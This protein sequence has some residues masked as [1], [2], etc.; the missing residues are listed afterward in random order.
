MAG[1]DERGGTGLAL[2]AG[3][4]LALAVAMGIGRFLYTP[5]LPMMLA[6]TT[7][8]PAGGGYVA[9]ANFAGYLAGALLAGAGRPARQPRVWLLAALAISAATTAGMAATE[10]PGIWAA[11]RFAGGAAS[12]CVLVTASAIVLRRLAATGQSRLGAVHFAGVGTGIA[13]SAVLAAPAVTGDRDWQ[14]LWL[15]GGA[16]TAAA[17]PLVA[18]LVPGEP[19]QSAAAAGRGQAPGMALLVGAYG[20]L[21][22]GYV[23]TA[24]FLVAILRESDAGRAA[25]TWVWLAV[26]LSAIP[27]VAIWAWAGRRIGAI[28]AFAL[29]MLV[30]AAGVALSALTEG[31]VALGIAAVALG[32]TFMGLTALGLTEAARRAPGAGPRIMALMTAAFGTG[33]MAGPALAG[34][35]REATGSYALPSLL[36]AGV[37]VVGAAL[38]LPLREDRRVTVRRRPE[39]SDR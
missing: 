1:R 20:C 4:L 33:Q 10:Q 22:F 38:V 27:S 39:A 30:E 14:T 13:L 9:A 32:G 2:A 16:A 17:L 12:A 21:G 15:L 18:R 3:G 23:V 11:L 28:R 24:T 5:A 19:P 25:E 8:T 7:L 31:V 37:L 34:W 36:A 6:G 26:G 29:A 35:L